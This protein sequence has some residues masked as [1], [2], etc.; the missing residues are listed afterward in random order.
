M[1]CCTASTRDKDTSRRDA[2]AIRI[3][4]CATSVNRSNI[5]AGA[6][7]RNAHRNEACCVTDTRDCSALSRDTF[8]D[9]GVRNYNTPSSSSAHSR[10]IASHNG[11]AGDCSALSRGIAYGTGSCIA[12][13]AR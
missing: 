2:E 4:C 12:F 7:D 11:G 3:I 9:C 13:S 5:A 6:E 8:Y 10:Y 1:A